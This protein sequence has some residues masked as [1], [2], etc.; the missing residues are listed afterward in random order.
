MAKTAAPQ[1]TAET[2]ARLASVYELYASSLRKRCLRLT[3]DPVAADDLA[4]EVF[5]RFLT[6]VPQPPTGMNVH[7]YLLAMAHNVW[8]NQIRAERALPVEE[9]DDARTADDR[10]ENDPVLSL[11]LD[12]QQALVRRGAAGLPG[13]Q[14]R[15][16]T[17]RELD[18]RSY[19]EIGA[20]LGLGTNAVAQVVWRARGQLRRALRRFQVDPERLPETCRA[21]L[22]DMSDLLDSS[23]GRGTPALESHLAGCRSCRRTL[24]CYQEAGSRLRGAFPLLPLAAM[25]ARAAG[26][27]RACVEAPAAIGTAATVTAAVV[28]VGG[29]GGALLVSHTVSSPA[30]LRA[31]T[32][33]AQRSDPP[34]VTRT[35][36]PAPSTRS[37]VVLP[38]RHARRTAGVGGARIVA[39]APHA[40]RPSGPPHGPA[41]VRALLQPAPP[42]ASPAAPAPAPGAVPVQDPATV[43]AGDPGIVPASEPAIA[44]APPEA[45]STH[46][47]AVKAPVVAIGEA[48]A[49]T[50]P[51]NGAKTPPTERA[52]VAGT[53]SGPSAALSDKHSEKAA[54]VEGAKAPQASTGG[55]AAPPPTSQDAAAPQPPA[56]KPA[57]KQGKTRDTD[58]LPQTSQ[59][60]PDVAPSSPPAASAPLPAA[61]DA[62]A[63]AVAPPSESSAP[64]AEQPA[65]AAPPEAAS[66]QTPDAGEGP[67]GGAVQHP[68]HP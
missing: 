64:P 3:G 32:P 50:R 14:R 55:A 40:A 33:A 34:A 8:V 41:A 15:A 21:M 46:P 10:I 2:G 48:T 27:L 56:G 58:V 57:P 20:E 23:E 18:G 11:L 68:A 39:R 67:L 6:K 44:A 24:A 17:L 36:V 37:L 47:E 29:G 66:S 62:Q 28:A 60:S 51:E 5:T 4:Q 65:V 16:L 63:P 43:P 12:E 54:K 42:P 35:R 38:A 13:R 9:I 49:K 22:D 52:K 45:G 31:A 59:A 53:A 30:A 25:L 1:R 19:A 7:G 26:T 61:A